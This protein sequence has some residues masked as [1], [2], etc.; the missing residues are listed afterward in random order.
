[1]KFSNSIKKSKN[2]KENKKTFINVMREKKK[3]TPRK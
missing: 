2:E 1:M 3:Y